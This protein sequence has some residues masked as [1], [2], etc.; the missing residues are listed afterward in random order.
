MAIE[1]TDEA[2]TTLAQAE[3][4]LLAAQN[5]SAADK[6]LV[7]SQAHVDEKDSI[8][9][10]EVLADLNEAQR[11]LVKDQMAALQDAYVVARDQ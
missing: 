11:L 4:G 5:K 6:A 2:K 3:A 1:P 8:G 10:Y 9:A 7:A